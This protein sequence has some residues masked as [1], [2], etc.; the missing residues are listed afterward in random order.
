MAHA[1]VP[2]YRR[3]KNVGLCSRCVTQFHW[4]ELILMRAEG[5]EEVSLT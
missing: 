4:N 5:L 2:T 3:S 1:L